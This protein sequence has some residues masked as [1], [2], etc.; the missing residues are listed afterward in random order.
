MDIKTTQF[1]I[2]CF[3]KLKRDRSKGG[4]PHKPILLLAVIA[5]YEA[6]LIVGNRIYITP[7]LVSAFK[8]YWSALVTTEHS[9][10][11]ALPFFHMKS[12][13]FWKL[14][15]HPGH[16][17]TLQSGAPLKSF[18]PLTRTV[19]YAQLD[20]N[21]SEL[22]S[23]N[24]SRALLRSSL[25]ATYFQG[26]ELNDVGGKYI[27]QLEDE[28]VAVDSMTYSSMFQEV[29]ASMK[30]EQREEEVFMRSGAFKRKVPQVYN[31]TCAITNLRIDA[32]GN[33]SMVDACHIVPF[34]KSYNSTISNGISLCPTMHRAFDRG[35]ISIDDEY[36]ILVSKQFME[37]NNSTH[38]I[39]QFEGKQILLPN[40]ERF[41]PSLENLSEHRKTLL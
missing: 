37:P 39:R 10:I 35:L 11:F 2:Q 31:N 18:G 21:L 26:K 29:L 12:E 9:M 4:A 13:P 19:A 30:K 8:S 1:Y 38:S 16:E 3:D 33:V 32:I 17:I 22:L 23:D 36:R 41:Y 34:A 14:V 40:E 6:C 15:A 20:C 28:I 25:L 5:Q 27:K 7:E 24:E